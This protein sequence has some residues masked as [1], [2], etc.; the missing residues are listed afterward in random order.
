MTTFKKTALA[1]L[2][3]SVCAS[4]W[5]ASE[6]VANA[7]KALQQGVEYL[8]A[9]NHPHNLHVVDLAAESVYKTC[10]LPG[11]F[12]P[13]VVQMTPDRSLAFVLTNRFGS[14]YGVDLDN[15]EI[16]F[17]ADMSLNPGERAKSIFSMALS[18]DGKQM[19]VVQNPTTIERDHYRV[20]QPRFAIY[21]T[22]AGLDAKP[23]RTF[24]APR[25]AYIM[26]T[27]KD[28]TV[29]LFGPDLY[30]VDVE[31]GEMEVVQ[32]IRNWHR[33]DYAPLDVLS[34]WPV[35]TPQ[36]DFTVLYT[37][38]KF[39]DEE[40]T[41]ENA[42]FQWGFFNVNM[43]SNEIE[44][45]EFAPLT[46][47]FFTALRSPKDENVIYTLLSSL[48]KWDI[49][50]MEAMQSNENLDHTYYTLLTNQDGSKLYLTG[51]MNDIGIYDADSLEKLGNI[52]LPGGDMS[53]STGQV[54]VR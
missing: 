8:V 5:A 18:A 44:A 6:L 40:K 3:A 45:R 31:T 9:V 54:F 14:V 46:E 21:D 38:A 24:E 4:G 11:G 35:Q 16:K 15:C 42:D 52:E 10:D 43:D 29:Y 17:S 47:V 32:P 51:T 26:Q 41:E 2:M 22:S 27:A 28:G 33:E 25:Q 34:F 12:G 48:V 1:M 19:Y 23:V 30:K 50:K 36:K 7:D 53:L 39:Q 49:A 13:G 37:T 20:E